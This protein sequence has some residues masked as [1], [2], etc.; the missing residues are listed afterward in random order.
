MVVVVFVIIV[1]LFTHIYR[2]CS[3]PSLLRSLFSSS[4]FFVFIRILLCTMH[5]AFCLFTQHLLNF[6]FL[7]RCHNHCLPHSLS[8]AVLNEPCLKNFTQQLSRISGE[9]EKKEIESNN[10]NN[11]RY[12]Y[13]FCSSSFFFLFELNSL[14]FWSILVRFSFGKDNKILLYFQLS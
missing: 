1:Y 13:L 10:V 4:F 8:L 5:Y 14:C 7:A 12:L 2:E 11:K 9:S 6:Q 3:V